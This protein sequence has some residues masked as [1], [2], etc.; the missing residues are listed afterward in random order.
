MIPVGPLDDLAEGLGRIARVAIIASDVI[1]SFKEGEAPAARKKNPPRR[2]QTFP[3]YR[4]KDRGA[5]R[6]ARGR[7]RRLGRGGNSISMPQRS[8]AHKKNVA[9]IGNAVSEDERW[10]TTFDP[11]VDRNAF[12]E[13]ARH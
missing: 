6:F 1:L 4:M 10:S 3:A 5:C 8:P 9:A 13:D 11:V 2:M 7:E 12:V